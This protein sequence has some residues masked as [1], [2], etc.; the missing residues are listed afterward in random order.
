MK[1]LK[2]GAIQSHPN[3]SNPMTVAK[4]TTTSNNGKASIPSF[5]LYS[6]KPDL[7][8]FA[9]NSGPNIIV[10]MS[11]SGLLLSVLMN[12]RN[13]GSNIVWPKLYHGTEPPILRVTHSL[14]TK[15]RA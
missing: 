6:A 9:P 12:F 14:A 4:D 1:E 15:L 3:P 11:M 13:L 2:I 10:T 8:E 5:N 7:V